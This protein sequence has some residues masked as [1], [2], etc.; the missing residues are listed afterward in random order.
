MWRRGLSDQRGLAQSQLC[1]LQAWPHLP[2]P[3]FLLW[4]GDDKAYP[5]AGRWVVREREHVKCPAEPG[6]IGAGMAL[7]PPSCLGLPCPAWASP[8]GSVLSQAISVSGSKG[9]CLTGLRQLLPLLH[10]SVVLVPCPGDSLPTWFPAPSP[11]PR[12]GLSVPNPSPFIHDFP[13]LPLGPEQS[14]FLTDSRT[15][16]SGHDALA[17]PSAPGQ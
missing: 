13:R 6:A 7:L 14:C 15:A 10:L 9:Q 3:H 8:S 16:A 1:P 11:S 17:T 5:T 4:K 12:T 2:A